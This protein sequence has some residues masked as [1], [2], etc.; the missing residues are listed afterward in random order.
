[1]IK[2]CLN[3]VLFVLLV[4]KA[5]AQAPV[6]TSWDFESIATQPS[7]WTITNLN[8]S[9]L[10][11]TGNS[12]CNG[13]QALRLDATNEALTIFLGSQP[14]VVTYKLKANLASGQWSGTFRVQ[15]SVNG[16]VWVNIES[17]SGSGGISTTCSTYTATPANAQSRYIRF[18]YENKVSGSN[19]A[20]DDVSIAEPVNNFPTLT[21]KQN[22]IPVF[23]AGYSEPFS[24]PVSGN[25]TVSFTLRNSGTSGSLSINSI[26]FSGIAASEYSVSSPGLPIS[27]N[28]L[29]DVTLD[30]LFSPTTAGTR[31]A[32]MLINSNDANT[33]NYTINLYG[34]GGDYATSPTAAVSNVDCNEI[35][36]YRHKLS[37][38]AANPVPDYYG[39]YL[40]LQHQN[41]PVS[42][43]PANGVEY[44]K[45]Q[46]IGSAKI[47]YA[48]K[49]SSG[50]FSFYPSG[51]RAGITYY[52]SIYTY[53][54]KGAVTSYFYGTVPT[55][56]ATSPNTMQS[57]N[58]YNNINVYSP[59][60]I[61]SLSGK[62]NP[63]TA[64][65]YSDYTHTILEN[66]EA[67]DTFVVS[68]PDI[69]TRTVYC[70][71]S[72][73][74]RPY[75]PP[76]N[77]TA[78][79]FSREHT[80]SHS[81][82]PTNPANNPELP[83]YNDQHNLYPTRQTLV[84]ATR[85]NY[86][87]GNVVTVEQQYLQGKLGLDANGRRVYEPRNEHKG[88]AA[89]AMMY[90]AVAYNGVSGNNWKFP[91]PIGN[92]SSFAI[93]YGQDQNVIKDWH[94]LY[95]PDSYERA[96]NDYLDS[97]QGNRNPFIDKVNYPC[98]IDFENM[99]YISNPPLACVLTGMNLSEMPESK[100][101]VFPNPAKNS[102]TIYT[103]FENYENAK[104]V[105]Y[106]ISGRL[107]AEEKINNNT[108]VLNLESYTKGIYIIH[109]HNAG[110]VVK[111]E[112][113]ILQ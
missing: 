36:S 16:A 71:Y 89:R 93:N 77:W 87:L 51:I 39:G 18:F 37:F 73:E 54:G 46:Y 27:I 38:N 53:N 4:A 92:C 94:F 97:L 47:V 88:R 45:G 105:L 98:F 5:Y 23:H 76:L 41:S 66:F 50:T 104:I 1:M 65:A 61:S 25:N 2:H 68:G 29:Q 26:S 85:C 62:I 49:P 40:V 48:G 31:A 33:P 56:S 34:V 102:T 11:Y 112:K 52:Y 95:P 64:I 113:L 6:P 14:G 35:K 79:N 72:G 20:V 22:A 3:I 60:F 13:N 111:S 43:F 75:N 17:Y 84:N 107:I 57:W 19:I 110:I 7:G 90:M 82:F 67:L 69:F 108:H 99:T 42:D 44:K 96:R 15:E 70:A 101:L 106:D 63:H 91:N 28:P 55:A 58:Y 32:Q 74:A 109:I 9:S 103:E 81:W 21:V 10:F 86:P 12:A 24:A 100:T 80:Y 78:L 8:S 30:V 59:T 83:E